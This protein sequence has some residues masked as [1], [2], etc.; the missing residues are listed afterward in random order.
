MQKQST[1]RAIAATTKR[2]DIAPGTPEEAYQ[3]I[4]RAKM[5]WDFRQRD[6]DSWRDVIDRWSTT[7]K[8]WKRIPE[9]SKPY[10]TAR[11]MIEAEVCENYQAFYMFVEAVLGTE[12]AMK[13]A[14]NYAERP[15]GNNNPQ[16]IN[17]YSDGQPYAHKVDHDDSKYGTRKVYLSERIAKE[18]PEQAAN[19]GKGKEFRTITEAAKKLGIIKDRPRVT[20]YTDDPE[21][22]GRYLAGKVDNDW[23]VDMYEAYV[24][25]KEAAK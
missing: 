3:A 14:D 13:L 7:P 17:Q 4:N 8:A 5:L 2:T 11:K 9:D 19:I 10:G 15:G 22:A 1:A 20:I 21:D 16:G 18:Y 12:W 25:E 23:M 6:V 24:K